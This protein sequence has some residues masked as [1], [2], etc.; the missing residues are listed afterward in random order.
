M[1]GPVSITVVVPA[2]NEEENLAEAL[3]SVRFAEQVVVVDSGSTDRTTQI[4]EAA[5][6]A[7]LEFRYSGSGPKKKAWALATLDFAHE[8]VLLLDGD[9]RVPPELRVEI[10]DA[11]RREDF[12]GYYVDRELVFM[13]RVMRSFQPNWNLRL[14]RHRLARIED[15]GLHELPDTGDNEIHEHVAVAGRVGYLK[16]PLR[17][18]DYRGLT[19]WLDR[20]NKYATWEAHRYRRLRREPLG[21]GPLELLRLDPFRRKRA[22]RRLWVR[23]PLRPLLRFFVWYFLRGGF[24][25]GREGFT[26][27]TLMAYHEFTIGAKLRELER[28]EQ[29]E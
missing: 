10:E 22:L 2:L 12:D 19:A 21:V 4:A 25:D 5:G 28:T 14:F 11:I 17:H 20:H 8:W 1:T 3:E 9:E 15:L 18:R 24:R 6:A 16:V 27:C 13:G 23:L 26:F 7:V 29:E